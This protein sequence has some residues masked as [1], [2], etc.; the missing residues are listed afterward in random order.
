MTKHE[1]DRVR[2]WTS[3]AANILIP[4]LARL[5]ITVPIANIDTGVLMLLA[6]IICTDAIGSSWE[7]YLFGDDM[8]SINN[9][10][11]QICI[12][13]ESINDILCVRLLIYYLEKVFFIRERV[14]SRNR[15]ECIS[16]LVHDYQFGVQHVIAAAAPWESIIVH[17]VILDRSHHSKLIIEHSLVLRRKD[18]AADGIAVAL[19]WDVQLP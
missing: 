11:V 4:I 3:Y 5:R 2:Y 8:T 7:F 14:L 12:N 10:L 17:T 9:L 6:W 15:L 19:S 18:G 1:A 16:S 13:Y